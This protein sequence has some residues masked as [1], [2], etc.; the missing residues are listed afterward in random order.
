MEKQN[1]NP[2]SNSQNRVKIR[3]YFS[4]L[5]KDFLDLAKGVDKWATI[6][7][8]KSKQSMTGANAWMLL[9][10]IMIASIG[11]NMNSQAVIIGGMLISPLMSP[12]LGIGLAVGINDK[13]ALRAAL[14][15]FLAAMA[16][17]F[18]AS[19]IYFS[20]TP[21]KEF[22]QQISERTQPN[23]LDILIAIFGGIA[24]IISIARKDISTTLPGVAIATALMP[25]LCVAGYGVAI[26]DIGIAT[27]SFYL[28]FLNSFFV[29]LT[30]YVI[31]RLM[32]FP[33]KE[34]ASPKDRIKNIK[35]IV[36]FS[37]LMLIPS[38]WLFTSVV[39]KYKEKQ[40][41][42]YFFD[43]YLGDKR[44]YLD[45]HEIFVYKKTNKR[46]LLMK[47]YGHEIHNNM[48][49]VFRKALDSL[50]MRDLDI[51]LLPTNEINLDEIKRL[52]TD[53]NE[54]ENLLNM[55]M[56]KIVEEKS[57]LDQL[58][59]QMKT[60]ENFYAQDSVKFNR[61]CQ[62]IKTF[63]PGVKE[64]S[65]SVSQSNNFQNIEKG[66]PTFIVKWDKSD[67]LEISKLEKFLKD[68]YSLDTIKLVIH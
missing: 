51:R 10:S 38:V 53:V 59:N 32:K 61:V 15:H 58:I 21:L 14:M 47:V 64:I 8:I 56:E 30:T 36:V 7:E 22:T 52:E 68:N 2:E 39:K 31:V 37:V 42:E 46:T 60:A 28:F 44:M 25:P 33:H 20:L 67:S 35:Y 4:D 40:K 45:N 48:I 34:Y 24:G 26:G 57:Q 41:L 13:E 54:V 11:L 5:I 55:R 50:E 12:I 23:F 66:L 6:T 63:I 16:I 43:K 62:N 19:F 1:V 18:A 3:E 49:P 29:A 9:C 65:M 27:A 17:A